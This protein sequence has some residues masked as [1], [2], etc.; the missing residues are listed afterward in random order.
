MPYKWRGKDLETDE[1]TFSQSEGCD[2]TAIWCDTAIVVVQIQ[3]GTARNATRPCAWHDHRLSFLRVWYSRLKF[4]IQ[5]IPGYFRIFQDI[6][7]YS[8]FIFGC[9]VKFRHIMYCR[10]FQIILEYSRIFWNILKYI[11]NIPDYFDA[12]IRS[13][14]R[15]FLRK[16]YWKIRQYFFE[17]FRILL[18]N[19]ASIFRNIPIFFGIF[20]SIFQYF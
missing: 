17:F 19:T 10:I 3:Y 1:T 7:Q 4:L 2:L 18:K 12:Y 5:N 6:F 9:L 20:V 13:L 14:F 11:L 16:I 8:D 15:S